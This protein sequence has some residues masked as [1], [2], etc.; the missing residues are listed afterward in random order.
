MLSL[1]G[2]LEEALDPHTINL[3]LAAVDGELI[4]MLPA[5]DNW[6]LPV[7]AWLCD[8][9]G[10]PKVL[11]VCVPAPPTGPWKPDSDDE[12]AHSL[13]PPNSPTEHAIVNFPVI[14]NV[15][16]VVDYG[17]LLTDGL[18]LEFILDEDEDLTRKHTFLPG[19]T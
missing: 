3:V 12:N 6:V 1:E 10:V 16:E 11:T 19:A 5:T 13:P 18:A 15:K 14:K 8:P 17:P 9:C 2:L 4:G 7:I